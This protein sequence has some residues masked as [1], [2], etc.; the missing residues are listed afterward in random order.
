MDR[1]NHLKRSGAALFVLAGFWASAVSAAILPAVLETFP[2]GG[3]FS[4][5]R[6]LG[7]VQVLARDPTLQNLP[8]GHSLNSDPSQR[9][10][11]TSDYEDAIDVSINGASTRS[12]ESTAAAEVDGQAAFGQLRAM[13]SLSLTGIG[14]GNAEAVVEF[15]D[16]I[17]FHDTKGSSGNS[18]FQ[19][20]TVTWKVDGV[21]QGAASGAVAELYVID[22]LGMNGPVSQLGQL[23]G[24]Y[25]RSIWSAAGNVGNTSIGATEDLTIGTRYWLY[26]RLHVGARG[27]T[28]FN[29]GGSANFMNTAQVFIDPVPGRPE[30]S[31]TSATGFDYRTPAPIPLPGS[32]M[33]GLSALTLLAL[34]GV[35][36]ARS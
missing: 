9:V 32:L 1:F 7:S 31:I 16:L 34:K 11:V 17:Q 6:Q 22:S 8:T 29:A 5:L 12:G 33:L 23:R 28:D 10:L 26:G 15:W 35:N 30:L 20:F 18:I 27:N 36:P 2:V 25:R 4:G 3:G 13:A 19:N 21:V 24:M 14:E